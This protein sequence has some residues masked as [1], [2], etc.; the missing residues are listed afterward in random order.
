MDGVEVCLVEHGAWAVTI[1]VTWPTNRSLVNGLQLQVTN[2]THTN[3]EV[4]QRSA[5]SNKKKK[6]KKSRKA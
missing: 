5:R 1:L 2:T 6:N 3:L 4:K